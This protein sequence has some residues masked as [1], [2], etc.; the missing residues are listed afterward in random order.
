MFIINVN[1]EEPMALDLFQRVGFEFRLRFQVF[2]VLACTAVPYAARH[3]LPFGDQSHRILLTSVLGSLV[4]SMLG[5][6]FV[7]NINTYPGVE[8]SSYIAP[9]LCASFGIVLGTFFI[10]HLE[11]SRSQFVFSFM[12]NML[13]FYI[14]YEFL[15][16]LTNV[17]VGLIPE[18][19][20]HRLMDISQIN[21]L[22]LNSPDSEARDL[23]AVAVDLRSDLS[24]EWGR[25]LA[26]FALAGLPVYHSKHLYESLTGR[27]ELESLSENNFGTLSPV[28]AYMRIKHASDWL[29]ALLVGIILLPFLL[30][31]ALAIVLDSPGSPIF[32]QRRIGYRGKSF[33][34]WKFRTMEIAHD[35]ASDP[36]SSAM[37]KSGDSRIT[38]LG[39]FLRKSR[40][41]ELPQIINILK[42]EMSWIGP[43]PE[44]E[45]LSEWYE[46]EIPFYRYRHIVRP[47]ISG[48]AQVSQG[49]VSEITDVRDKLFYDFFYIKNFSPWMDFLICVRTIRTM[50]IG[51]G[52][53]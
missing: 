20:A 17:A 36:R 47:G 22:P 28:S 1:S 40:L 10:F 2:G 3:W 4:A 11:Y 15:Q 38:R 34:V 49:H 6:F 13:F 25:R 45:I 9:S 29:V 31:L 32:R 53:R 16:K 23:V 8:G 24:D 21:W 46:N 44:A 19:D 12:L 48:W 50:I 41:D 18:G 5:L 7:R 43:R 30:F 14:T 42:G 37:T 39:R 26:D 33:I 27:V 35:A 51:F 52:A